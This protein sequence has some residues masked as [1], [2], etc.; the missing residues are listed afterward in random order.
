MD[1]PNCG[2]YY[3]HCEKCSCSRCGKNLPAPNILPKTWWDRAFKDWTPTAESVNS[4]P[5]TLRK[6]IHDLETDADPAGTIS[7]NVLMKDQIEGLQ[8]MLKESRGI[9]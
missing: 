4:L 2:Y 1:C 7:Q 5:E 3:K 9:K 8:V 6:Y